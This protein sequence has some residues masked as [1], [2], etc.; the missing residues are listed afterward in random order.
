MCQS[1]FFNKVAGPRAAILLE[2]ETLA[3]V[4][5]CE[6]CKI[7][8][9]T[10]FEEQ[11]RTTASGCYPVNSKASCELLPLNLALCVPPRVSRD[12]E[13]F[14]NSFTKQTIKCHD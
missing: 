10:Y 14:P 9:K 2:K 13:I 12:L 11:L 5:S 6:L 4:W 8:K 3:Q 7:S 1:L